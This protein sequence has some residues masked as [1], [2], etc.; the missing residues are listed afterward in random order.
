MK[1]NSNF[2]EPLGSLN[3]YNSERDHCNVVIFLMPFTNA[4]RS[5]KQDCY[6]EKRLNYSYLSNKVSLI[7]ILQWLSHYKF[8]KSRCYRKYSRPSEKSEWSF[9]SFWWL[10]SWFVTLSFPGLFDSA[11]LKNRTF[12]TWQWEYAKLMPLLVGL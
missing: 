2:Q 7:C 4:E 10:T 12:Q 8:N 5:M 1:G 3:D 6:M 9:W 11:V